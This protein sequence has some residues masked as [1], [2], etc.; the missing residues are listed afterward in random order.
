VA[1]DALERI[2][3]STVAMTSTA[4][5]D[6]AGHELTFLAWRALVVLGGT[7]APMRMS[8]VA[9]R[10]SLSRPSTSKLIRRLE[11]RGL[12]T[13]AADPTDGRV[14]LV[15]LSDRGTEMR[16][17]VVARRREILSE[18]TI[19]PLPQTLTEGLAAIAARL[20]RWS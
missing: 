14:L 7:A 20:D 6:A 1:L 10:L 17:A 18:A 8:D 16:A 4:V 9:D 5:V 13:L 19:D 11:R 3:F 15:S 2:A 12:V